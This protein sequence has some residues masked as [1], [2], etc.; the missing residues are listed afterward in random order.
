[1]QN[2][3]NFG[4][5]RLMGWV[6]VLLA[7]LLAGCSSGQPDIEVTGKLMF[8]DKPVFPGSIAMQ[9]PDGKVQTGN[10][11]NNGQFKVKVAKAG[12]YKMSVQTHKLSGLAPPPSA[13]AGD[14]ENADKKP[15]R[16]E[17]IIPEKFRNANV[18]IPA[19]YGKL[20]TTPLSFEIQN[21]P[22]DLGEI[23]LR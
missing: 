3:V 4:D 14:S 22:I 1:M 6:A 7:V 8:G 5:V 11:N 17:D 18:S 16:R 12:T 20:T 21:S 10:L 9:G 19:H 15:N 13:T 23:E 2:S